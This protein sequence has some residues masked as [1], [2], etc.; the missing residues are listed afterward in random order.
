VVVVAV[1]DQGVVVTL[2]L[3]AVLTSSATN[4][5]AVNVNRSFTSRLIYQRQSACTYSSDS[6]P[7]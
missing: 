5:V 1:V 7:D 2:S 6:Y 4:V 3:A